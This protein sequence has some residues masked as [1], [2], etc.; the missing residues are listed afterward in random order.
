MRKAITSKEFDVIIAQRAVST[1]QKYLPS[2]YSR[3][4][5]EASEHTDAQAL[6]LATFVKHPY[7][8]CFFPI[9]SL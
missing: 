1:M 5:H 7:N 3:L 4:E 2:V 9:V 6:R 8:Y